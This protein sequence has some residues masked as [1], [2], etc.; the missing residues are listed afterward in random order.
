MIIII[1][2]AGNS[3]QT[4]HGYLWKMGEAILM[5]DQQPAQTGKS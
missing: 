4:A 3:Y 1:L 2:M 5:C